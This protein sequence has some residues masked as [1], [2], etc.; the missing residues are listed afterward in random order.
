MTS[1]SRKKNKIS[2]ITEDDKELISLCSVTDLSTES[3]L[4]TIFSHH[5]K[6]FLDKYEFL[7]KNCCDPLLG[8]T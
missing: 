5:K 7:Q 4:L 2:D 3:G 8:H 1:Y 6:L